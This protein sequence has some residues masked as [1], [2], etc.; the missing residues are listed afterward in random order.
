MFKD[1]KSLRFF[2]WI[3]FGIASF[4]LIYLLTKLFPFYQ[5]I[6][7]FLFR[8]L[9]PFLIAGLIAYLL[10]PIVE[11]LYEHKFPRWL[12]ILFIYVVFFGGFGFLLYRSYP[13]FVHQLKDLN[14]NLPQFIES[15]HTTIYDMYVKTSNLPESVHDKMD[16]LLAESGKMIEHFLTNLAKKVTKIMDVFI[17]IAV[18]PVLVFYM[19]KDFHLMKR[20]LW[21]LTPR[22]YRD[23]G[24]QLIKDIDKS[25]GNYIRGQLL[26]CFFV[27]LT[28]YGI[29]WFINMKYPLLLALFMGITN[30]IPYF[31]PILGAIPAVILAFTISIKMVVYVILAVF[32]VQIMEG[33]LL[34]PLIVGKSTNTHPIL[35]IF[36]LLVGGEIGGVIGMILAVPIV[37]IIKVVLDHTSRLSFDD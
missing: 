2:Y 22:K 13:V 30:I 28:T 7:S 25:L 11:K 9:A 24:K 20:V 36:A 12:A 26:V 10:H 4:L 3:L 14:Q 31:G 1:E 15:Y 8:I 18:I 5:S 37:T 16:E 27:S 21:R 23:E 33:N 32:V 34:S 6:L 17:I 29:L 35:I 19:L